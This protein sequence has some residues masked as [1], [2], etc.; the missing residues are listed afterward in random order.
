M[1]RSSRLNTSAAASPRLSASEPMGYADMAAANA[2]Q[3]APYNKVVG[4]ATLRTM[5][6]PA[7]SPMIT[8]PKGIE[9][10]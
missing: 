2:S 10:G 1:V 3:K 9:N 5:A 8:S 4:V 6:L 7:M